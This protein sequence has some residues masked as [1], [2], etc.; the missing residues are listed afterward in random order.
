MAKTKSS[1][2]KR[3]YSKADLKAVSDNPEWTE[4]EFARARSFSE[5][6]PELDASIKP[7]RGRPKVDNPK[8]AV[9]LRL[10]PDTI[11]K[12]KAAGDDWRAKMAKTLERAKV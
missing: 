9:T 4:K 1:R 3:G 6:F 11:E 2:A 8:E 10:S 5:V 12:F 7:S